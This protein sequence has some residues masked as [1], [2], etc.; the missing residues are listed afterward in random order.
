VKI[1][2]KSNLQHNYI[3]KDR[4]QTRTRFSPTESR[5]IVEWQNTDLFRYLVIGCGVLAVLAIILYFLPVRRLRV[6]AVILGVLT[7]AA[8]GFGAGVLAV[9]F[10][11]Y[12]KPSRSEGGGEG[13]G[14]GAAPGGMG[15][16]GGGMRGMMGGGGGGM[17]GGGGGGGMRGGGGMGGGM[18]GGGGR[19]GPMAGGGGPGSKTQLVAL[20]T[21]LDVLTAKPLEVKLNEDQKSKIREKLKGLKE[22]NDL[23]EDEAKSLLDAILEIVKDDQETLTAAG[24]RPVP[25][26][27]DV[28][29][30]PFRDD[31][32][33]AD[34]LKS[35]QTRLE[36]KGKQ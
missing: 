19:G 6:P 23:S 4:G 36:T 15:G 32:P 14:G 33:N 10:Y 25:T 2:G 35:L 7:G 22:K 21:K 11:G 1:L 31:G 26:N 28:R 8:A 5:C 20:V 34:H 3:V 16:G 30:N 18:R 13:G 27:P 24:F 17:R 9:T 12:E 29:L